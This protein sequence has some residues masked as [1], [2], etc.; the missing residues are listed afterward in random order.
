RI[1]TARTRGRGLKASRYDLWMPNLG[2]SQKLRKKLDDQRISWREF[3]RDYKAELLMLGPIDRLSH[4]NWGNKGQKF[5]LRL[6][7]LLARR[8]NVTILCTCKEEE[9]QCHR[10]VFKRFILKKTL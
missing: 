7:K 9:P 6:I 3:C 4:T 10:H 1:H 2:P 5:T 8:G